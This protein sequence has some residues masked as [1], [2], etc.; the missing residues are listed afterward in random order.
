MRSLVARQRAA[1]HSDRCL[2]C[3]AYCPENS[4]PVR[5]PITARLQDAAENVKGEVANALGNT[6]T[7]GLLAELWHSMS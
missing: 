2:E 1:Y 5:I 7:V 4:K 3:L 6:H